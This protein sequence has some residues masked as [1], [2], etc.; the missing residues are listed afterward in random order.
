[1]SRI[2]L[3]GLSPLPFENERR[4]YGPGI[5]TWQ[6]AK[7]L[8]DDGHDVRLITM[9]IGGAYEHSDFS[10]HRAYLL[11]RMCAH[12]PA[13]YHPETAYWYAFDN[14]I[15]LAEPLYIHSRWLDLANLRAQG[16]GPLDEHR[17]TAVRQEL[18]L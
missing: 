12:Q 7:P 2:L 1:M 9:Q 8:V 6:F 15:P 17:G 10:E 16:C 18:R 3:F 4:M 14:A 5:R 11:D 13:A